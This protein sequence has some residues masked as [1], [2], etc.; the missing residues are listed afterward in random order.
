MAVRGS[1]ITEKVAT[2]FLAKL[3]PAGQSASGIGEG[4]TVS[5]WRELTDLMPGQ[6]ASVLRM[7][8]HWTGSAKEARNLITK[9]K[10]ILSNKYNTKK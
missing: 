8:G 2:L 7:I 5:F 3:K 6:S 4:G 9:K 10:I 1:E